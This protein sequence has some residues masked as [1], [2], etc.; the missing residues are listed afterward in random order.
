M[1]EF[2]SQAEVETCQTHEWAELLH[3]L[4]SRLTVVVGRLQLLRRHLPSDMDRARVE[5]DLEALEGAVARLVA[6]VERIEQLRPP[7]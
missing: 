1:D 7:D 5:G 4:R 6:A 2:R 3:E